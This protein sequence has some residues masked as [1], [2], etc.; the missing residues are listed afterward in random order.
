MKRIAAIVV[1]TFLAWLAIVSPA[2]AVPPV[3]VVHSE[4]TRVG[5]YAMRVSFSEWPI[6]AERSLDLLFEPLGGVGE[7]KGFLRMVTPSGGAGCGSQLS[8]GIAGSPRCELSRHPRARQVWG[9]DVVA[10]AEEGT[11]RFEFTVEGP[12]GK[13]TGS[14][15]IPVGPRPGPPAP[16]AWTIGMLP[17]L[18]LVPIGGYAWVRTRTL[19]RQEVGSWT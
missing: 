6:R 19:R 12:Q 18:V 3:E 7:R 9:L 15:L 10:L 5:P 16:L 13:G 11:W 17:L 8:G 14:M 1:S 2:Q 4:T